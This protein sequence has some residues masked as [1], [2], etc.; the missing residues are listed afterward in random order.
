VIERP[1]CDSLVLIDRDVLADPQTD[2]AEHLADAFSFNSW[3]AE[4]WVSRLG[5]SKARDLARAQNRRAGL[6]LRV[7]T[8]RTTIEAVRDMLIGDGVDAAYVRGHVPLLRV[9]EGDALNSKA[10]Q[11]GLIQP[12]DPWSA[13]VV[14]KLNLKAGMTVLD[15]CACPGTKTTQ[16]VECLGDRGV[17]LAVDTAP[18]GLERVLDS[19]RRM[20]GHIVRGILAED[21]PTTLIDAG[22][23]DRVLADV[24]CS[25]SGVLA[26]RP[27]ARWRLDGESV[28][29]QSRIQRE[30]LMDAINWVAPGGKVV[31]S[32]CS[33][34]PE[35]NE[36]VVQYAIHRRRGQVRLANEKT[37]LPSLEDDHD[38]G[39]WALLERV[40]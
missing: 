2:P 25:N 10:M 21:L 5:L 15:R 24:P 32:T 39:Y 22:P 20:G 37:T 33:I 30:L 35:E 9:L 3:L 23:I 26:R 17:V 19:V 29:E 28:A 40:R 18:E 34:E 38:G 27:E 8:L 7:N 16:I 6:T 4:R 12:Q 11:L 14:G 1:V 36:Q 13:S 31:Y